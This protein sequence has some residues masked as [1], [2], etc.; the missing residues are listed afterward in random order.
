LTRHTTPT[1]R[2]QGATVSK[3]VDAQ[4]GRNAS[5]VEKQDGQKQNKFQTS[6]VANTPCGALATLLVLPVFMRYCHALRPALRHTPPTAPP[7]FACRVFTRIAGF[8]CARH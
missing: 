1:N 3:S 7:A 6:N 4:G 8:Y 5:I 2:A